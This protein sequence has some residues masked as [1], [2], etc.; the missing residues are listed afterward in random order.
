MR[1]RWDQAPAPGIM[2]FHASEG[3]LRHQATDMSRIIPHEVNQGY[4][5]PWKVQ[6]MIN[7]WKRQ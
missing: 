5:H 1:S 2:C 7:S 3:R 6:K 4:A